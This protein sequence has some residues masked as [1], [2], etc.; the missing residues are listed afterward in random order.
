MAETKITNTILEYLATRGDCWYWKV[1]DRFTA[2]IPD[3][4]GTVRNRFFALEVKRPKGAR[5]GLQ[6]YNIKLITRLG[7]I[8]GVVR[9]VD[10]VKELLDGARND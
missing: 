5:R 2:G 10:D 7:G 8:A 9:S 6:D 1:C 4:V 3:I